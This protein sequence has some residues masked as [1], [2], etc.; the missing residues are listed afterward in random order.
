MQRAEEDSPLCPLRRE[1]KPTE[2]SG[3]GAA[4]AAL[5]GLHSHALLCSAGA[6]RCPY[7]RRFADAGHNGGCCGSASL[8]AAT[9]QPALITTSTARPGAHPC[10][11]TAE[12]DGSNGATPCVK[13]TLGTLPGL[14]HMGTA[15]PPQRELCRAN[16]H[17]CVHNCQRRRLRVSEGRW[18]SIKAQCKAIV[19]KLR[20]KH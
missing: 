20:K 17:Q 9:H 18:V 8:G 1:H 16:P 19:P 5:P 2:M 15:A 4:A 10:M 12:Y 14:T 13:E 6:Q 11:V 3:P 7:R